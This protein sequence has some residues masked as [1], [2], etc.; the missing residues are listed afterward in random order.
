MNSRS[1]LQMALALPMAGEGLCVLAQDGSSV[2]EPFSCT[3]DAR[4]IPYAHIREADAMWSKRVWRIIDLRE[5]INHPLFFPAE[6]GHGCPSLFEVVRNALLHEGGITAYDPGPLRSD[7]SFSKPLESDAIRT[8][9]GRVDTVWTEDLVTGELV[10]VPQ[11]QRLESRTVTRYQIK[12]DWVF[13][14]QRSAMVIRI[15]GIAPMAEVRGP[16]GELRGHAPLFWLYYP[17]C[18]PLFARWLS[19]SRWNDAERI[20]FEEI[21]DKRIF[22][23]TIIKVSN[24]YDRRINEHLT[25]LDALLESERQ[26]QQLMEFEFDLWHH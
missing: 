20:T 7:D 22:S 15:V 16:D 1:Y 18:R 9:Y 6:A 4:A 3:R 10:P 24:V 2:L 12:E 19:P 13:D 14:K 5:K 26:K 23:S 25:G 8:L 17:E 21:F 11:V